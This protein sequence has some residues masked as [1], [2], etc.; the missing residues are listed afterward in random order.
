MT[1]IP[2]LQRLVPKYG[3][4]YSDT[5]LELKRKLAILWLRTSSKRGWILDR[6]MAR[7]V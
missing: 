7:P 4:P 2:D 3:V 6:I 1:T 5:R